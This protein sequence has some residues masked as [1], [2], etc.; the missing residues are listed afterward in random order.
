MFIWLI[1]FENGFY[2]GWIGGK[3]RFYL[4]FELWFVVLLKMI[5]YLNGLNDLFVYMILKL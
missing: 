4:F 2:I 3:V 5:G 1:K